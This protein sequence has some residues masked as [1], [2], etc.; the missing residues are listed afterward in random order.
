MKIITSLIKLDLTLEALSLDI[1]FDAIIGA[2][3][4]I[5]NFGFPVIL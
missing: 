1:I 4:C 5:R 3:N 2:Y